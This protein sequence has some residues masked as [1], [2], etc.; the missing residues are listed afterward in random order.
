MIPRPAGWAA[1]LLATGAAADSTWWEWWP[2]RAGRDGCLDKNRESEQRGLEWTTAGKCHVM[3]DFQHDD[4]LRHIAGEAFAGEALDKIT[5]LPVCAEDVDVSDGNVRLLFGVDT[6]PRILANGTPADFELGMDLPNDVCSNFTNL[7]TSRKAFFG[8]EALVR[9]ATLLS[10]IAT[11][12]L[13]MR[14]HCTECEWV[15]FSEVEPPYSML[16]SGILVFLI[17]TFIV[18]HSAQRWLDRLVRDRQRT[19]PGLFGFPL[20]WREHDAVVR[21]GTLVWICPQEPESRRRPGSPQTAVTDLVRPPRG[22]SHASTPAAPQG[23]PT[24][25]R[26]TP[27]RRGFQPTFRDPGASEDLSRLAAELDMTGADMDSDREPTTA[28]VPAVGR[29]GGGLGGGSHVGHRPLSLRSSRATV[30][31]I[32][33]ERCGALGEAR[34]LSTD[35][36]GVVAS[37][38]QGAPQPARPRAPLPPPEAYISDPLDSSARRRASI[39]ERRMP[40][41]RSLAVPLLHDGLAAHHPTPVPADHAVGDYREHGVAFEGNHSSLLGDTIRRLRAEARERPSRFPTEFGEVEVHEGLQGPSRLDLPPPPQHGPP[42]SALGQ[43]EVAKA[44]EQW[45]VAKETVD[46]DY[47]A[48]EERVRHVNAN[49]RPMAP[50]LRVDEEFAKLPSIADRVATSI[51][52]LYPKRDKEGTRP[53][54]TLKHCVV[55]GRL[56]QEA[57]K[58]GAVVNTVLE[59]REQGFKCVGTN[60]KDT[61]IGH[62]ANA[63]LQAHHIPDGWGTLKAQQWAMEGQLGQFG[64]C[65]SLREANSAFSTKGHR[66]R[67]ALIV[68]KSPSAWLSRDVVRR[69]GDHRK[70]KTAGRH[71]REEPVEIPR[72]Y[73][74]KEKEDFW[75][76]LCTTIGFQPLPVLEEEED[77]QWVAIQL[78]DDVPVWVPEVMLTKVGDFW[79]DYVRVG[80]I[81][82]VRDAAF[83]SWE[84]WWSDFCTCVGTVR[85]IRRVVKGTEARFHVTVDFESSATIT[86]PTETCRMCQPHVYQR[87]ALMVPQ[88]VPDRT[89]LAVFVAHPFLLGVKAMFLTGYFFYSISLL[90]REGHGGILGER[91]AWGRYQEL[92]FRLFNSGYPSLMADFGAVFIYRVTMQDAGLKKLLVTLSRPVKFFL[93]LSIVIAIPGVLTHCLPMYLMYGWMWIPITVASLRILRCLRQFAPPVPESD[94][95]RLYDSQYWRKHHKTFLVKTSLFYILYRFAAEFVAVVILQTNYNYAILTYARRHSFIGRIKAEYQLREMACIAEKA[96]KLAT[97]LW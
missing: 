65:I 64:D 75:E 31:L 93:G 36:L 35:L 77:E 24:G 32:G 27:H 71:R 9:N 49:K 6:C 59:L 79:M 73:V 39:W 42:G 60:K 81:G 2:T 63:R 82:E 70:V 3:S 23:S 54:R 62:G 58:D 8:G 67:E 1:L 87:E 30:R 88:S 37:L 92:Y 66:I 83:T 7:N 13:R 41:A 85:E 55:C 21:P 25:L 89:L 52:Q 5:F 29:G 86:L 72:L 57:G 56:E 76:Q 17:V 33:A 61:C 45:S 16:A 78:H 11:R 53:P 47:I 84:E 74:S 18:N 97:L 69:L 4:P 34:V 28:A 12:L 50:L 95:G 68:F 90:E 19:C 38:T 43:R 80:E 44:L 46:E 15:F 22:H 10:S 91:S 20:M 40:N 14:V 51:G 48:T 96:Y 26:G 94:P